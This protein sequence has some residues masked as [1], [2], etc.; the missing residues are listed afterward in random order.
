MTKST[1]NF[2]IL[3]L[4][5]SFPLFSILQ[6]QVS[7]KILHQKVDSLFVGM[8][9]MKTPGSAILVVKDKKVILNKG[10]GLANLE[11]ETPITSN[12]VFDLASVAKQFTGYAI[13]VLI[14]EGKLSEDTDVRALIPEFPEFDQKI[15]IGH[16]LHHTSGLR[17]W[18]SSLRLAGWSFDDVISFDQILRMTYQQSGLNFEPGSQYRYS[19][20]GYNILAEIVQRVSGLSF[21]EWTNQNIFQPLGMKN[22]FFLDNHNEVIAGKANAYYL[23][24]QEQYH[25][26]PNNLTAPG[27]SSLYSTT[28]DLSRW[29]IHLMYPKSE[30][31]SV[32]ERMFKTKAL[33]DGSENSYAYGIDMGEFRGTKWIAHSGSWASFTTYLVLVPEYD[34]AIVV[35]N[36]QE[37]NAY[38]TA[39]HIAS[40]YV[41]ETKVDEEQE[42]PIEKK[43]IKLSDK[44]LN[45]YTGTYKLGPAWY[46]HIT[47]K[48]G[49]L[50]T[51]A[52]DEDNFPM[53]A[54]SENVFLIK[55]YGNRTMTFHLDE[56]HLV[57]NEMICPK[58]DDQS[59]FDK[60]DVQAFIGDYFS[61]EL[62]TWYKV[63][64]EDGQLKLW[65]FRN[66]N[67]SLLPAWN[68]D[69]RAS[70]WYA[71]TVE[72]K[73]DKNGQIVGLYIS[74]YR[75]M[76]Q[77][78]KK[79]DLDFNEVND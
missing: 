29:V 42:Q 67:I 18:T 51:Q 73:R 28:E 7:P 47:L 48:D 66:G 16:L 21:R 57:Y 11:N 64:F 50:W 10:Y 62:N 68:D 56:N 78:F 54:L 27:S 36:N 20:S 76:K 13:A 53:T 61:K 3:I 9:D 55:A 45:N 75:S 35:L 19:N 8:E 60:N 72:F 79:M 46:V 1:T 77:F 23:N 58:M 14:E 69:F 63:K 5:L 70:E 41:P 6:A 52:T 40:L 17:D 34:L 38:R 44:V 15:T 74:Q 65:H 30:R 4:F 59:T 25:R 2:S 31:K 12:T 39:Y 43:E 37:S 24:N 33:N 49:Q 71:S 22:T 32:V 26:T